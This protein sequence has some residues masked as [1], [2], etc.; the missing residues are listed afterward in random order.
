MRSDVNKTLEL[1]NWMRWFSEPVV[2]LDFFRTKV[3]LLS[4]GLLTTQYSFEEAL[5]LVH[6]R[7]MSI[8]RQLSRSFR[9]RPVWCRTFI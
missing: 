5:L 7:N 8:Q 2:F 9:K 6:G 3:C 4:N 1:R